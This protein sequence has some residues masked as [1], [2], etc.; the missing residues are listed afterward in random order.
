MRADRIQDNWD[1]IRD[2]MRIT[3]NDLTEDELDNVDGNLEKLYGL[4]WEK[5][6]KS[7]YELDEYLNGLDE[8]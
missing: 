3:W 1:V 2:D 6:G 7:R 4:M 8:Y 5:Y